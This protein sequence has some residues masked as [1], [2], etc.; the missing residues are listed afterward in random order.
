MLHRSRSLF[1]K[2]RCQWRMLFFWVVKPRGL[3]EIYQHFCRN[4]LPHLP[5]HL[6]PSVYAYLA[7]A[8]SSWHFSKFVQ[9]CMLHIPEYSILPS[10]H[11]KNPKTRTNA[12]L[13][14][15]CLMRLKIVPDYCD[16][17]SEHA[18]HFWK[19]GFFITAMVSLS[20]CF[21]HECLAEMA[22]LLS[23]I[24]PRSNTTWC[25][26]FLHLNL[27]QMVRASDDT[28]MIKNSIEI[29]LCWVQNRGPYGFLQGCSCTGF[30]SAHKGTTLSGTV[31]H[32]GYMW[33]LQRTGSYLNSPNAIMKTV[34][35]WQVLKMS[36]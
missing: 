29:A 9:D 1:T 35:D 6:Q 7:A 27:P 28:I 8:N 25:F 13:S 17:W 16:T 31:W 2:Q 34:W 4:M 20:L 5:L 12:S 33:L 11:P 19:I 3:M 32:G 30:T 10:C 24:I 26:S 18:V 36:C 22:W 15:N 14:M 21:V 23:S